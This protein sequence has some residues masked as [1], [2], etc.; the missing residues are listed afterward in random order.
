MNNKNWKNGVGAALLVTAT[1]AGCNS[2]LTKHSKV[3]WV[4]LDQAS[5]STEPG[6]SERPTNQSCLATRF[7]Q[8][9][10]IRLEPLVPENTF[11][12]PVSATSL[13][14]DDDT[15]YVLEQH[16]IIWRLEFWYF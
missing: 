13:P 9:A 16:G 2:Q 1:V 5:I 10:A 4:T 3:D 7:E 14:G 12:A 6:L 8:P 15:L 11:R